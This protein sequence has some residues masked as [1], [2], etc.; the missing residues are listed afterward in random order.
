MAF[1]LP[2]AVARRLPLA[3]RVGLLA[4]PVPPP[5]AHAYGHPPPVAHGLAYPP[6]EQWTSS[7]P[8]LEPK[9]EPHPPPSHTPMHLAPFGM[10]HAD[11]KPDPLNLGGMS[12]LNL[13]A[14][15]PPVQ[16][17]QSASPAAS[18]PP[19]A[20]FAQLA[21]T[22]NGGGSSGNAS[23]DSNITL[24]QFLLELL[25]HGDHPELIQ[26]TNNEGEFKLLDAEAVARLWG[27]RKGKHQMNYDKLSRALR[28]YYDKQIIKKVNGQ[29]FVYRFVIPH[30]EMSNNPDLAITP[31]SLAPPSALPRPPP[32]SQGLGMADARFFRQNPTPSSS[33]ASAMGDAEAVTRP[34]TV[35]NA[36]ATTCS[37]GSVGSSS[38]VSS[39]GTSTSNLSDVYHHP[40]QQHSGGST[41]SVAHSG[42]SSRPS[43]TASTA[44]QQTNRKRKR[45]EHS[46]TLEKIKM[47]PP[48]SLSFG[49]SDGD[50]FMDLQR[51][52]NGNSGLSRRARPKPMPLDLT[53]VSNV[54]VPAAPTSNSNPLNYNA[55]MAQASP[56]FQHSPAIFNLYA[57]ASLSAAIQA[58]SPLHTF[59]AAL[60]SPLHQFAAAVAASPT[61][62]PMHHS[63][64]NLS[65]FGNSLS[66]LTTPI[67][68]RTPQTQNLQQSQFFEFPPSST[69]AAH[70]VA[71]ML[72]SP[73]FQSPFLSALGGFGT[74]SAQTNGSSK[75]SP[76]PLKTPVIRDV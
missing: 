55:L 19:A 50:G 5:S 28:Y 43:S 40:P 38:G 70:L 51:R 11:V 42:P 60:A 65:M 32:V 26:W 67:P 24:W 8:P 73:G 35:S 13:P 16:I 3:V 30:G 31:N 57:A 47:E 54:Q 58:S 7:K 37:P 56:L 6:A 48:S 45:E 49:A 71:T 36:N 18:R 46:G 62:N 22:P 66:A 39:A 25:T 34:L 27:E 59:P 21:G 74:P 68:T 44:T 15:Q 52:Q 1:P 9:H 72:R 61:M 76:D 10:L 17:P 4:R 23:M 63:N 33:V 29:K 64:N 12:L 41:Q 20:S 53:A 2:A 14:L 75:F 69:A